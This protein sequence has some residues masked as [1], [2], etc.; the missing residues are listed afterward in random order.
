MQGNVGLKVANPLIAL[1]NIERH[2]TVSIDRAIQ[3]YTY[4]RNLPEVTKGYWIDN[5]ADS[6]PV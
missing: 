1:A 3:S 4:R 6:W 5:A 2:G